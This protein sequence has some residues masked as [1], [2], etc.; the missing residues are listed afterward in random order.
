MWVCLRWSEV[1]GVNSLLGTAIFKGPGE[2]SDPHVTIV[3]PAKTAVRLPG[4]E[5][6][7]EGG[8]NAK[9]NQAA[10]KPGYNRPAAIS[11]MPGC[12]GETPKLATW[13]RCQ[14]RP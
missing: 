7:G 5:T 14:V 10:E 13:S 3:R 4:L 1:P 12:P 2:Y 9:K 11:Q 8:H 6:N